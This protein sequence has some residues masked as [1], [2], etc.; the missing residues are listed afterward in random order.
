MKNETKLAVLEIGMKQNFSEHKDIK[1][2]ILRIEAKLDN[3]IDD[4]VDKA[5][6][7]FWRNWIVGGLLGS[8][9]LAVIG[10]AADKYLK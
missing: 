9:F 7:I 5:E 2:G 6:F 8:I 10:L 1:S 4:K 3:I